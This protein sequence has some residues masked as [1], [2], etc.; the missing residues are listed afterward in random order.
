MYTSE[1]SSGMVYSYYFNV[2][3]DAYFGTGVTII[4]YLV[5][6]IR[7]LNAIHICFRLNFNAI[8]TCFRLHLYAI[9]L[10]FRLHL[11][12]IHICFRL[13]LNAIHI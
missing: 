5:R 11:N 4:A 9:H 13:H 7:H 3:V 12:A 8:L 2:W 10:C 1:C 6:Q